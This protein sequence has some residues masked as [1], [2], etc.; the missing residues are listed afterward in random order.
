MESGSAF[1][2]AICAI[3]RQIKRLRERNAMFRSV[4]AAVSAV[5]V[6]FAVLTRRC[7]R[8]HDPAR[9]VTLVVPFPPG[10]GVDAMARVVAAKL[11]EAI[12]NRFVVDN[13]GRRRRAPSA[14]VRSPRRRPMATPAARPYRHHLD[15]PQPLR[16]CG[17]D[18]RKDF[19]PVGLV[20]SMPVALLAQSFVSGKNDRGLHRHGQEGPRQFNLGTSALGTGGYM[21]A[22]LFKSEAPASMSRSF[23]TRARRR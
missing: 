13:L 19:A 1:R 21:W 2:A 20:A 11:S 6:M 16:P 7:R 3:V 10:G 18:P 12:H 8:R 4:A 23:P 5:A 22:E 15:Q 14:P 17:Y 9:N